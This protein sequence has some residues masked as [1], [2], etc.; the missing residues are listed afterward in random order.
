M[1]GRVY[2]RGH[3]EPVARIHEHGTT[4]AGGTMPPIRPKR[5]K[6]LT[7]PFPAAYKGQS[8]G[9]ALRALRQANT[10]VR[11]YMKGGAPFV[12]PKGQRG[13]K[14]ADYLVQFRKGGKGAKPEP[15]YLMVKKVDLKPRIGF[16]RD[17]DKWTDKSGAGWKIILAGRDRT[18]NKLARR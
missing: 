3:W 12:K 7:I 5:V 13:L 9:K 18:V 2:F 15:T 10:F 17:W 14:G 16:Y 6:W 1:L 8:R 11:G 4:G